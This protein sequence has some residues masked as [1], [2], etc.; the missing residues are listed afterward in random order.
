[1]VMVWGT[2]GTWDE[3]VI[4]YCGYIPQR[5]GLKNLAAEN[6]NTPPD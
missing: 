4:Y 1:M 3:I 2:I 5:A 6:K